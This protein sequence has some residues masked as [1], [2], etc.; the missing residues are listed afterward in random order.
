MHPFMDTGLHE[1]V[2]P[3]HRLDSDLRTLEAYPCTKR[4]GDVRGT[5]STLYLN[6]FISNRDSLYS[7]FAPESPG[8][9]GLWV[10]WL[11]SWDTRLSE[12]NSHIMLQSKDPVR[13]GQ[14]EHRNLDIA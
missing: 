1:T 14:S 4:P 13:Y 5:N 11:A 9:D 3:P 12:V 2:I 6:T 7:R 10:S 8:R